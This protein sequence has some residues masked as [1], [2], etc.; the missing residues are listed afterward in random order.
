MAGAFGYEREH[1][2]IS[3][4]IGEQRLFPAVRAAPE[5]RIVITGMSCRH[6]V[7]DGTGRRSQHAV[8]VLRQ[9]LEE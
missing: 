9:A 5:A 3:M 6:Q 1:Y 2:D 4:A 8:E 7:S